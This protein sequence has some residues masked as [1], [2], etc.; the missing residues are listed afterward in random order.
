MNP[1][2]EATN[3]WEDFHA[4][5]AIKIRAQL[6]PQ[7]RPKY[8]AALTPMVTYEEVVIE[9]VR[10]VKPD[11][12]VMQI[13]YRPAS[14]EAVAIAPAPLVG[15]VAQ[16]V[17]IRSQSLEIRTVEG[18]LVTAIEILS[19]VNKRPGH[20]A[21][22]Q[23]QQKR[24]SLMDAGIHLL[25]IDLLR[26]GSRPPLLT[27]LPD[28]P[29]FIFL[30]RRERYPMVEIWP[31]P[32]SQ[33]LPVIP[34]PLAMP[35]PDVPLDLGRAI[36]I[37]YDEAAYELRL[38]YTQPPPPPELSPEEVVWLEKYLQEAGVRQ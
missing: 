33:P 18:T 15:Q 19:P 17:P 4:D 27:P 24:R 37:I 23:Y 25:E 8:I 14:L 31:L 34:V 13:D 36:Q 1:Y 5:L 3:I 21:F 29:H 32:L 26:G 2:L 16:E 6:A 20:K 35:D 38:D 30:T 7:L 11:V 28:A 10:R 12:G 22:D 9:E